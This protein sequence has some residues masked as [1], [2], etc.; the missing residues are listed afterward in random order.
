MLVYQRDP[1]GIS[2]YDITRKNAKIHCHIILS[3]RMKGVNEK[4][5]KM[6]MFFYIIAFEF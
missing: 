2:M 1:E 6:L 4:N 5:A 3:C